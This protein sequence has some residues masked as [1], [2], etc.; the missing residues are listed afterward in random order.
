M[1]NPYT[2]IISLFIIAGLLTT[3]W[4]LWIIVQGRKT[5]QWPSVEGVI[6][7]SDIASDK[8]D[9]LPHILFR[10]SVGQANYEQT[11]QFPG[12]ITPTQ[13][14]ATSYVQKYPAGSRIPVYYD[15]ENPEIATLEPGPGKGDWLVFAMGLGTLLFGIV[16]YVFGG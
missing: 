8:D 6:Q 5:L 4:G 14:F 7:E 9:L 10:Y 1:L 16:F 11:M 15:P 3:M 13:E 12:D 2:I